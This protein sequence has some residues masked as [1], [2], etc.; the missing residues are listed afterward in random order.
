MPPPP[1]PPPPP[2]LLLLLRC[3]CA[4]RWLCLVNTL[5][6]SV[7]TFARPL[8]RW[9]SDVAEGA[10][11]VCAQPA[12]AVHEQG[13]CGRHGK[14]LQLAALHGQPAQQSKWAQAGRH[15]EK[16]APKARQNLDRNSAGAR[17]SCGGSMRPPGAAGFATPTSA[18][19]PLQGKGVACF[20]PVR[21]CASLRS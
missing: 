1:P 2:L 14:R 20:R 4:A 11:Y 9:T 13:L 8:R 6:S 5:R 18:V 7:A 16:R 15:T 21:R 17:L 19:L 3:C 10:E 12:H